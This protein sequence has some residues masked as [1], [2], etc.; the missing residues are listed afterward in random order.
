MA[1]GK[2]Y[3]WKL[4]L[5]DKSLRRNLFQRICLPSY[6]LITF[7]NNKGKKV[8]LLWG[9]LA[10]IIW[11][12]PARLTS[13]VKRCAKSTYSWQHALGRAQSLQCSFQECTTS[14]E[15][16]E[17]TRQTEVR[18]SLQCD[19]PIFFKSVKAMKGKESLGNSQFREMP[20][21]QGQVQDWILEQ[22]EASVVRKLVK[23][24][25]LLNSIVLTLVLKFW[26]L[27]CGSIRC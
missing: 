11:T 14:F 10:D 18:D 5:V 3:G 19:S 22:R 1:V 13:P 16:W 23:V 26:L 7:V 2:V 24:C 4:K 27:Y 12:K 17:N 15:R 8:A 9:N 6:L 25:T 20:L 21:R